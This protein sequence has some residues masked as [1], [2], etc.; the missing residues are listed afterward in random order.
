MRFREIVD[1]TRELVHVLLE[2]RC[3]RVV[4]HLRALWYAVQL[5]PAIEVEARRPPGLSG[6][7]ARFAIELEQKVRLILH[8]RP[9]VGVE[10]PFAI[11]GK[12]VRRAV[13]VPEDFSFSLGT[14]PWD[15]SHHQTR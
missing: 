3:L 10:H 1:P 15:T 12:N 2:R 13:G 11:L 6:A 5:H 7:A 14:C 8:L 9:S 4:P